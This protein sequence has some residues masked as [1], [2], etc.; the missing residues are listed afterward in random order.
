MDETQAKEALRLLGRALTLLGAEAEMKP[1]AKEEPRPRP[2]DVVNRLYEAIVAGLKIGAPN[3][4]DNET[5]LFWS[6]VC[7]DIDSARWKIL[8][9]YYPA[10]IFPRPETPAGP[11]MPVGPEAPAE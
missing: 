6:D 5:Y 3:A 11:E 10:P 4:V 2:Y 9:R 1:S 7:R 8:S